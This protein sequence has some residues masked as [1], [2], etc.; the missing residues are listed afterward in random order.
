MGIT[1]DEIGNPLTYYN[2]LSYTFTWKNGRQLAS[3]HGATDATFDYNDE[4]I[5]SSKTVS[6]VKHTYHLNGTQIVAEEWDNKLLIYLYD[7]SGSPIGMQYRT[8]SYAEGVFD[9]YWFEKNLQG[10]IVAVYNDAGTLLA[11][12]A[13]DAWGGIAS[14]RY[15]NGGSSTAAQYNP[16]RY[17][18]YYR[19]SETGF[20]YLNSRYYDP[21]TGRFINADSQL[22]IGEGVLGCNMY[23]YCLNN[24]VNG[25]DPCGTCLHR[26][27]FWNDCDKCGGKN[28]GTKI[29]DA[30]S[31]VG[32][33][34][35]SARKAVG[36]AVVTT[37][38]AIGSAAVTAGKAVGNAVVTAGKAIGSVAVTAVKAVGNFVVDRFSTPEKAS[39]TLS[40]IGFTLDAAAACCGGVAVGFSI[41]TLGISTTTAGSAAAILAIASLPFHGLALVIDILNEE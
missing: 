33:A 10:D 31:A 29:G 2:G 36:D 13:Y 9:T 11:T 1:Y 39:N 24:P 15:S 16:F 25:Y 3:V 26:W 21:N 18:G 37:G 19:D 38:K 17:R 32:N 30:V 12:Y 8:T 28:L 41:P 40:A 6:G 14:L 35:V 5:R 34:V 20:Y 7:E 22:N 27:D 4:G 23:T